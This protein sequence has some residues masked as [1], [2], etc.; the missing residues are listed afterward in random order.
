M[1]I[2]KARHS[3][4]E[5]RQAPVVN[6]TNVFKR[7]KFDLGRLSVFVDINASQVGPMPPDM[8]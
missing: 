1:L 6:R 3:E 4:T 8:S 7:E 2:N 5:F